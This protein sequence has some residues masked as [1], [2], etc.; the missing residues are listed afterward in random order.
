MG[1]RS[2]LAIAV[3]TGALTGCL[4]SAPPCPQADSGLPAADAGCF[5][6]EGGRL[7]VVRDQTGKL[8]VPGGGKEAGESPQ[9]T[10]HR[11]TWEET[12]LDVTPVELRGVFDNGFHLFR[13]ELHA[14][15]GAIDPP[16]RF[17]IDEA[18]WLA[19]ADF[20]RHQWRY[21]EQARSMAQWIDHERVP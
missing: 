17:E 13:C 18:F 16:L 6:V 5:I 14:N 10:A 3:A 9:C 15:S 2:L 11:E 20:D 21:P 12:G 7:L 8:S 1:M 19:P 4:R